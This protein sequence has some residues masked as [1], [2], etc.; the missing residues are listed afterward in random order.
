MG[1]LNQERI[2]GGNNLGK[3]FVKKPTKTRT[4]K[5][6]HKRVSNWKLAQI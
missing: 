1:M 5:F 3:S 4:V 2:F 6:S